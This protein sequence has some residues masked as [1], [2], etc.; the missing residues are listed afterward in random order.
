MVFTILQGSLY[1]NINMV[2][3]V[4]STTNNTTQN[5]TY[6]PTYTIPEKNKNYCDHHNCSSICTELRTA[7]ANGDSEKIKSITQKYYGSGDYCGL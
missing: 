4:S 2:G 5:S 3:A 6:L 7:Y 1:C